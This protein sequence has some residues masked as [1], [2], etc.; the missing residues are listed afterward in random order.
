[1]LVHLRVLRVSLEVVCR[2]CLLV[3][4]KRVV[5]VLL[6]ALRTRRERVAW[7]LEPEGFMLGPR[8]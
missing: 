7:R 4:E 1:M 5:V 8:Y 3:R 2:V 6:R